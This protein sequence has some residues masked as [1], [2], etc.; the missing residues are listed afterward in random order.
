MLLADYQLECHADLAAK[1]YNGYRFGETDVYNPWSII[2]YVMEASSGN[3]SFPHPYWS[4]TSSNSIVH[5]LVQKADASA[6][7]ELETLM[8]GG[9]IEKPIHEDI[10]YDTVYDSPDNLWNFL[11]F[12]GYLKQK[13]IC[14]EGWNLM[15]TM[16]IPNEEV[17]YIYD[18]TIRNWFREEIK[19]QDLSLLYSAMCK[20]DSSTFQQELAVQLQKS[21]SYMDSHE[22]FYH[23]FVLGILGNMRDYLVQSNRGAGNGRLD[24]VVRNL[25]VKKTPVILELK[26]SES[27]KGMDA[28]CDAAL[29]QIESNRYDSWLPDEGYSDVLHYGVAFFKKQ[30]QVKV[31]HKRFD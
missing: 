5:D 14:M 16:A 6:K 20:G 13:S 15:I 3:L 18:N 31:K 1:W 17:A 11:F 25:D 28:A 12:T 4:N 30:C 9:T 21:I 22:A 7:L 19:A 29:G 23:G 8:S 24:I 2:N 27:F 10:T 26:V